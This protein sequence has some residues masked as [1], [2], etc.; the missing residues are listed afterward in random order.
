VLVLATAV[1]GLTAGVFALY[2]NAVM[3]GLRATDDRTFVGAFQAIDRAIINPVWLGGGFFGVL[4]LTAMAAY[5]HLDAPSRPVLPWIV[6]AF[7]LHTVVVAVTVAVNVPLNDAIKAAGD[8]EN[9]DVAAT[10]AAFSEA[11]WVAW[12][13]IRVAL[14]VAA[15]LTLCVALLV[16]GRV[17]G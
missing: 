9:I 8:P 17:H 12:N 13:G 4:V 5:L 7:V 3:P 2:S 15:L 1:T 14:D 16:H 6:A 11:R 10:R